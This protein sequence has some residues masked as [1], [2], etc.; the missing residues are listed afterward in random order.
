MR[1]GTGPCQPTMR[2]GG[3]GARGGGATA[4]GSG[5][6]A[7][8]PGGPRLTVGR[9]RYR[10][11]AWRKL[12]ADRTLIRAAAE[13]GPRVDVSAQPVLRVLA[14]TG[15]LRHGRRWITG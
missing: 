6:H 3:G 13:G 12:R 10:A 11:S 15:R 14:H 1:W 5:G 8:G 9:T 2:R 7:A 4:R